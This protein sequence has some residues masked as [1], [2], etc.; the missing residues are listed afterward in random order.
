MLG[1]V[2]QVIESLG[3]MEAVN[4]H[5]QCLGRYMYEQLAALRH[6]NGQPMVRVYGKW[7]EQMKLWAATHDRSVT[8]PGG[9]AGCTPE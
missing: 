2:I 9:G 6:S 5:T 3:G 7:Q 8:Q 4:A 1:P